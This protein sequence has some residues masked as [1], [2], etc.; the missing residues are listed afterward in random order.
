MNPKPSAARWVAPLV[1]PR[2]TSPD[3]AEPLAPQLGN[4]ERGFQGALL[5]RRINPQ[6]SRKALRLIEV[7]M[8]ASQVRRQ[9]IVD[10]SSGHGRMT[11]SHAHLI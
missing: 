1:V 5:P 10:G 7:S 3:A 6:L 9:T 4:A 8:A 2:E 11:N